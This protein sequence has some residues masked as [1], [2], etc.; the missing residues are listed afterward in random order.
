M[1]KRLC[2]S[3]GGRI[4]KCVLLVLVGLLFMSVC[5]VGAW[6]NE[7]DA[8]TFSQAVDVSFDFNPTL[9]VSVSSA[10]LVI[11]ELV[12]GNVAD[13]NIITIGV[14]TNASFGYTLSANV[15]NNTKY[16][17][18][19]LIRADDDTSE[20][21]SIAT[22]ATMSAITTDNAWGF[23]SKLTTDGAS[24]ANYSGLPLYSDTENTKTILET[25]SPQEANTVD[26]KIAA[27]AGNT[28]TA[29]EY[30]N[31]INFIA[32][33]KPEPTPA[34]IACEMNKICYS[35][36]ALD[37]VEGTMGKQTGATA[38]SPVT[39]FASNFSRDGYG[40]AGWNT[41]PDY[42]GTTYGPNETIVS[43]A[44]MSSG[45]P[46]YA[47]WIRSRG[48][49][50]EWSG[51]VGL[52][53]GD[54]TALTDARDDQT[55]AVAKLAD[56][57]CW[58]IENLRLEADGTSTTAQRDLSQGYGSSFIGLANAEAPWSVGAT[59]E[60]S[61]Y[62]NG[63][64]SEGGTATVDLYLPGVYSEG[65]RFPRYNNYNTRNRA[66]NSTGNNMNTYFYGNYYTWAAAIADTGYYSTNNG[67][68]TTNSLCPTGWRLPIGG[69][70]NNRLNSDLWRLIVSNL[71]HGVAPSTY[72][73]NDTGRLRPYYSSVD[74][75]VNVSKAVRTYP[76]NFTF[77]GLISYGSTIYRGSIGSY[78]VS[79]AVNNTNVYG[80]VIDAGTVIPATN[81]Y[82]SGLS[83][84]KSYGAV[85]RCLM[86]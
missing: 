60:N 4:E 58:M 5:F 17:T 32:V 83:I 45:L 85:V 46:L 50:Q 81:Y 67:S 39:L 66:D 37:T 47:V 52:N 6:N 2:L 20:F 3:W 24:W 8:L 53:V 80:L 54:V 64:K 15:G 72:D 18:R 73:A 7:A 23:S 10:D 74:S 11:P 26:F 84:N 34:P 27:R 77:S 21:A 63:T 76:N 38:S 44:D 68:V 43:P 71:N 75:G 59:N 31:V 51:C 57:K 33:A 55:Y 40:F 29:G 30:K 22:D 28:I 49:I 41:A 69:D 65:Y 19:S 16:D 35:K 1:K 70:I 14:S 82:Y 25:S 12:P 9:S 56:G 61:V 79:T 13:S 42:S 78:W 48:V 86:D 62:Y 36:N